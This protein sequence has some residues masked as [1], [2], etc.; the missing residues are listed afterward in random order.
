MKDTAASTARRLLCLAGI[1]LFSLWLSACSSVPLWEKKKAQERRADEVA[2]IP[3]YQ[4][5]INAPAAV[6]VLLLK[7][8]DLARFQNS[9]SADAVSGGELNR[10]IA[11]APA[12]ARA[13]METE[14]YFNADV[15]AQRLDDSPQ[16][17]NA[18]PLPRVVLDVNPGP[19]ATVE[20]L[21]LDVQGPLRDS[22]Q[23]ADTASI[24]TWGA[25][26]RD[27][28]LRP[29]SEFRQSQWSAAKAAMLDRLRTDGYPAASWTSTEARIDAAAHTAALNV[30]ADSGPLYRLGRMRIEGLQ[31]HDESSV[32]NVAN[33]QEGTPYSER[34]LIDY[35]ER[36][37]KLDLFEST[38]VEL[39]PEV[40]DVAAATVIVRLRESPLQ[41]ATVGLGFS[42]NTGPRITL[43]HTHRRVFGRPWIAKNKIEWGRDRQIVE[44]E[45]ISHPVARGYRNLLAVNA[46][47]EEAEGTRVESSRVRIGR[48]LDTQ[49]I[50][51]LAFA[52][53]LTART[54]T[55]GNGNAPD[56]NNNNRAVSGNFHWIWRDLDNV[57]LPTEGSAWNLQGALGQARSQTAVDGPFGR[58]YGRFTGYLPVGKTWFG[59][60]RVEAAQL[61]AGGGVG[62]PDPLLFR[63]GG[64]ESV[65]GYAYR[66]L[67]PLKDGVVSSGRVLLTGSVELARPLSARLPSLWWATFLDA[68]QAADRWSDWHPVYGYGVG[69]RWRSPVG[70]LRL[71]LA[72]GEALQKVRLHLSVGIAF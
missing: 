24:A 71:D 11:A 51:R 15:K 56:A 58:F 64:D 41:Q 60:A 65:R 32:R 13:L 59:S 28:L 8:L 4:L 46:S 63:A 50:E 48:S 67:G 54:S 69:L 3:A 49:R 10:L 39:D 30:T 33:F 72:Y 42:D 23:R 61:F 27:W 34:L 7:F 6:R 5:Q 57:L 40:L 36:I 17:A 53:A 16:P 31:R 44:S 52:E 43:E 14:G 70:P 18:S 19:R 29:D 26:H 37:R 20:S 47:R 62:I 25:L 55:P 9:P 21:V 66:S 35:T 1:G 12:Q 2:L 38:V 22:L 45:L 68:G